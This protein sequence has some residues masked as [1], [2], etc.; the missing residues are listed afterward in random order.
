MPSPAY[1]RF[2][3]S[4][5]PSFD[6]WHDGEGYDLDAL[7]QLTP[8][9]HR[10]ALRLLQ[11]RAHTDVHAINALAHLG[12]EAA[13]N[14]LRA[15]LSTGPWPTRLAAARRLHE[16]RENIDLPALLTQAIPPALNDTS[17]ASQLIDIIGE[18]RPP[19]LVKPLLEA[20]P[21][22]CGQNAVHFAALILYLRGVTEQPFDWDLRP[23]LLRFNTTDPAQRAAALTEL[24]LRIK[25][26]P[27][28]PPDAPA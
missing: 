25:G 3:E 5:R 9:E 24:R 28:N 13:L 8:V 22:A 19:R 26:Y 21:L 11:E 23:F 6:R 7:N 17:L 12:T 4:M 1:T 2:I 15:A 27:R 16:R 20:I 18:F 14:T 10:D